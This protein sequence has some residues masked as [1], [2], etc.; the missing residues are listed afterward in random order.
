MKQLVTL[1]ASLLCAVLTANAQT[2]QDFAAKFMNDNAVDDDNIKCVTV[3][4]KMLSSFAEING[5]NND[6]EGI[7][8]IRIIKGEK[9]EDKYRKKAIKLLKGS[10]KRY[11]LYKSKNKASYG[12]CLWVRKIGERI[13]ELV[14]VAPKAEKNFMVIDFTG[15]ISE[16]F[17]ENL[18]KPHESNNKKK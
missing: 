4:P 8:S 6:M 7:K 11:T 2:T 17:V 13:A 9:D 14:Y 3:G 18:V 16:T 15:N 12:D 5:D 1:V 10:K